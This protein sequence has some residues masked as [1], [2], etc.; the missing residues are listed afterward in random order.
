MPLL[1]S[2]LDRYSWH[3]KGEVMKAIGQG[4]QFHFI[5]EDLD[6]DDYGTAVPLLLADDSI[7]EGLCS[8]LR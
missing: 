3:S 4:I 8:A 1:E 2:L 5:E 6:A 7:D